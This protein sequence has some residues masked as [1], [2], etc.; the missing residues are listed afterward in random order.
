[1]SHL[2]VY[3]VAQYVFIT[4]TEPACSTVWSLIG[5]HSK[6][7]DDLRVFDCQISMYGLLTALYCKPP[8]W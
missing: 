7:S 1:M 5:P 6:V 4:D 2:K 8:R 3:A